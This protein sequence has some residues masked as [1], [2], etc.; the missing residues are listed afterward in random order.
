VVFFDFGRC[1][2]LARRPSGGGG[3]AIDYRWVVLRAIMSAADGA[4]GGLVRKTI[5]CGNGSAGKTSICNRLRDDGFQPVYKQTTGI[6]WYEKQLRIRDSV[7]TLQL[8]DIG[9]Q[10]IASK[11]LGSYIAGADIVFLLYDVTDRQSFADLDDW[12]ALVAKAHAAA[13][14]RPSEG[15]AAAVRL[16]FLVGNKV[17]LSHLRKVTAAEHDAFIATH[18]LAGGFFVSA[19]SGESVLTAFTQATARSIGVEL[20]ASEVAATEK[21]LAAHLTT[22]GD[23]EEAV[24]PGAEAI[25]QADMEAEARR[26]PAAGCGCTVQ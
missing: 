21:V 17:D 12:A 7:V 9:G 25:A 19:R 8:H 3:S 2:C 20:T 5:I 18:G 10:S 26:G 16:S 1:V 13:A 23:A 11:M 14:P 15:G 22:P 6:D 4:A 24:R